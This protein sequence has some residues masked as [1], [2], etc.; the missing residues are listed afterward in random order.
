MT[1]PEVISGAVFFAV[2]VGDVWISRSHVA[3][4]VAVNFVFL[5]HAF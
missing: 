1:A 4:T 5:L 3:L 2:V